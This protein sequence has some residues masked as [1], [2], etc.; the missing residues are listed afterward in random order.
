MHTTS[1]HVH[2]HVVL[3]W[4]VD[5]RGN[6]IQKYSSIDAIPQIPGTRYSKQLLSEIGKTRHQKWSFTFESGLYPFQDEKREKNPCLPMVRPPATYMY[7]RV[8]QQT[9][10]H[11]HTPHTHRYEKDLTICCRRSFNSSSSAKDTL[12]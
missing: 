11:T 6:Y 2:V 10:T 4:W 9:H 8:H 5:E 7:M 3:W 1:M 12:T